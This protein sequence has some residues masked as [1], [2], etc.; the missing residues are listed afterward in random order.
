MSYEILIITHSQAHVR[1]TDSKDAGDHILLAAQAK[2]AG[3]K[4]HVV[5]FP[6]L[7]IQKKNEGHILTSYA[8]DKDGLVIVPDDKGN[9]EKQKPILSR[10]EV[11]KVSAG[12]G[13]N[14]VKVWKRYY[15]SN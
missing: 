2:K 10:W 7:D 1:D 8:F 12:E 13:N 9:K 3:V 14:S 15:N 4:V 6:G 11:E 5:D